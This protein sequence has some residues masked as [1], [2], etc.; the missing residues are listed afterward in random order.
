M[1]RNQKSSRD[2]EISGDQ[3]V[4]KNQS[5]QAIATEL[6]LRMERVALAISALDNAQRVTQDSLQREVSV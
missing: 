6:S 1:Q 3:L 5:P 2:K 4:I